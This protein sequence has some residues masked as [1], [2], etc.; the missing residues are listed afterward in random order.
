MLECRYVDCRYSAP[1]S[2]DTIWRKL[3]GKSFSSP[4][5]SPSHLWDWVANTCWLYFAV[6]TLTGLARETKAFHQLV[7]CEGCVHRY[8]T[9]QSFFYNKGI[10]PLDWPASGPIGWAWLVRS[11]GH[12]LCEK[13]FLL[14]YFQLSAK[15]LSNYL[16]TYDLYGLVCNVFDGSKSITRA[17]GWVGPWKLRIFGPWNSS[18]KARSVWAQIKSLPHSKIIRG[19]PHIKKGSLDW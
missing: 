3:L 1:L 14:S 11:S 13:L 7:R 12:G 2:V 16:W 9:H 6:L 4:P 15:P 5:P 10:V 8:S 19:K 18:S 17:I